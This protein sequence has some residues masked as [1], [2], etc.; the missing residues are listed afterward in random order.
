MKDNK[1][2]DKSE[3]NNA[4]K[5]TGVLNF[6]SDMIKR[7]TFKNSIRKPFKIANPLVQ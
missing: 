1:E 4:I 3:I 6:Y 2:K 5:S 7:D